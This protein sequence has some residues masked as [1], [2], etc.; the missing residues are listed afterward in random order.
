MFIHNYFSHVQLSS[1]MCLFKIILFYILLHLE[2]SE[3]GKMLSRINRK[4]KICIIFWQRR[5]T[6]FC[7]GSCFI[8]G[9]VVECRFLALVSQP[10]TQIFLL[11]TY[12]NVEIYIKWKWNWHL[13]HLENVGF[14]ITPKLSEFI[15]TFYFYIKYNISIIHWHRHWNNIIHSMYSI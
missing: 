14:L 13:F 11:P 2:S 15:I 6:I 1:R 7:S 8:H 12:F 5:Q 4:Q 10:V 3:T 9:I